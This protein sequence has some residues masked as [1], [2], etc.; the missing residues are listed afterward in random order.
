MRSKT[1]PAPRAR[2]NLLLLA[3]IAFVA[4]GLPVGLLGVAWPTLRAG[5][6]LPLDAIGLLF[7]SSTAGYLISSFAIARLINRF[8]IGPL[9]LFSSLASAVSLFGYPLAPSWS[10]IIVMGGVAG[11]GSGVLDAGLNTYLAAE[12]NEGEMQWLH[13]SFGIGATLSPLIMTVSLAQFDSWR[14]GYIFVGILMLLLAVSFLLTLSAWKRPGR[15]GVETAQ[16]A[17]RERGLLDY[18]TS[19]WDTLLQPF[20]WVSVLMFLLYTGAELTLGNWTYTLFTEGRGVSPQLAGLWAGGFWATFTI[21]RVLAGLYAQRVR[22]NTLMLSAMGLALVGAILFWWNPLT[23]VSV[24]GVFLAGFGMAPI[25]PGLVSST[26]QR[27]GSRHAANTIGIQMSAAGLGGA[28][29][30]ALAG[31]LAQGVSLETIP[32]M[33]SVSLFGLLALY[34]LPTRKRT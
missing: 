34:W 31:A 10:V 30:P 28:L 27:V 20:T 19:L 1:D 4:L 11:L 5:F 22:L 16:T 24:A 32:V 7:I 9:L 23:S 6:A 33:L 26:P 2:A 25:F 18:Q 13:A 14:P 8:G 15:A 21:G 29:L 12:Y 3:Y 17:G